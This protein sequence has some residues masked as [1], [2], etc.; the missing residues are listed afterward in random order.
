MQSIKYTLLLVLTAMIWGVAFVVQSIGMNYIGPHTFCC[1]RFAVASLAM[2]P[3][4]A[5]RGR[6]GIDET[7]RHAA[8]AGSRAALNKKMA[9]AGALCGAALFIA[10]SLQ[11][12]GLVTAD[13]GKS[14]FITAMYIVLVPVLGIF[15]GRRPRLITAL[16][17]LMG[18]AGLYLLCIK[19]GDMRLA[20]DDIYLILCALF[21]SIQILLLDRFA[22][23]LD[24][25]RLTLCQFIVHAVLS[26]VCVLIFERPTWEGIRA[27]AL[28]ILYAGLLSSG[29][30]YTMQ[31]IAQSRIQPTLASIAMSLESVFSVLAGVL[32]LGERLTG[33]EWGGCAMMFA[34]VL[35]AALADSRREQPAQARE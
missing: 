18:A 23:G 9:I 4:I 33:R 5:L 22:P 12:M 29:I 6:M 31:T 7:P 26:G 21:F 27:C 20:R 14:G 34:A 28:P 15:I 24:P 19:G 8:K 25:V 16:S 35:L 32:L 11:Q 13:A 30:G 3:V 17:A 1:L 2:L 10:S